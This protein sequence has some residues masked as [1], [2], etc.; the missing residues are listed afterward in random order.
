MLGERYTN[1]SDI[2]DEEKKML[3]NGMAGIVEVVN[4]VI[5][6]T[7]CTMLLATHVVS[8]CLPIWMPIPTALYIGWVAASMLFM[9]LY[10]WQ[11][12]VAA[13]AK[14]R[15]LIGL[16]ATELLIG[17]LIKLIEKNGDLD[18]TKEDNTGLSKDD[19]GTDT[20]PDTK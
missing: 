18:G 3:K 12:S 5:G 16:A 2:T 11:A 9:T 17:Q 10:S 4:P 20:V 1:G 14:T 13:C 8:M 15:A 6:S 7:T 19:E